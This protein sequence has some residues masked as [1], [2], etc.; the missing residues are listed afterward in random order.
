[1]RSQ[2]YTDFNPK[3]ETPARRGLNGL[4]DTVLS[5]LICFGLAVISTV[6]LARTNGGCAASLGGS[7]P[8]TLASLLSLDANLTSLANL[9]NPGNLTVGNLTVPAN[10]TAPAQDKSKLALMQ[11]V[12]LDGNNIPGAP[13]YAWMVA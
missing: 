10:L 4:I 1:L 8:Q 9:T 6:L 13:R 2:G 3:L 5:S 12:R 11:F 7:R